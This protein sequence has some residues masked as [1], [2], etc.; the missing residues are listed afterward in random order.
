MGS[1]YDE[2]SKECSLAIEHLRNAR[3]VLE[4]RLPRVFWFSI[5]AAVTQI[6]LLQEE[7]IRAEMDEQR[8]KAHEQDG[9]A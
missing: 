9:E 3:R 2:A 7:L 8:E 6:E 4:T 5:G 1:P